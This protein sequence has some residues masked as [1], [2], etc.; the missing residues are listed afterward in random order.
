MGTTSVFVH[1]SVCVSV[2]FIGNTRSQ[3]NFKLYFLWI[4]AAQAIYKRYCSQQN[5][6]LYSISFTSC[7]F[8]FFFFCLFFLL[9]VIFS[10][11]LTSIWFSVSYGHFRRMRRWCDITISPLMNKDW[12][13]I[14]T[15]IGYQPFLLLLHLRP[16]TTNWFSVIRRNR[17]KYYTYENK[18]VKVTVFFCFVFF[19][20]FGCFFS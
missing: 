11:I 16:L 10:S 9:R 20:L 14:V 1:V 17:L 4:L 6:G 3:S 5:I 2:C 13:T 12:K 19:F 8:V 7:V 18:T 15:W